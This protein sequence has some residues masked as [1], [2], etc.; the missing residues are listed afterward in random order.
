MILWSTSFYPQCRLNRQRRSSTGLSVDFLWYNCLGFICYTTYNVALFTNPTVQ[1][2]YRQRQ[3]QQD[4]T[5]VRIP[6]RSNDV[7]FAIHALL[8]CT[9]LL[10]Q[11]GY[12]DGLSALRPSRQSFTILA[13]LVFSIALYPIVVFVVLPMVTTTLRY[14][15]QVLD[16]IYF[17]SYV[18]VGI[19]CMKYI[20]QV[21]YNYRRRS[22]VG[23]NIWQILLD[24]SGGLF[25]TIQLIYD[26]PLV[27]D[28]VGSNVPKFVLG[29]IS[30][31]FDIVFMVQH[32]YLYPTTAT[33]TTTAAIM[34]E[35]PASLLCTQRE[36]HP[37]PMTYQRLS[38]SEDAD[39][40]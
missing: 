32:Y 22:T 24:F 12:Y 1:E 37:P 3:Q 19:T 27:T 33:S 21:Y 6:V 31:G 11:V 26:A 28:I 30:I 25:S 9:I 40:G 15:F 4:D 23:W 38:T 18:K 36:E 35:E 5:S 39:L 34:E 29:N 17:L 2:Q 8:L 20:P 16:Y 10:C 7:A 14:R 13:M